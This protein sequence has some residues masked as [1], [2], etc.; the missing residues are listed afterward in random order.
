MVVMA[1]KG[2]TRSMPNGQGPE[3]KRD[4]TGSAIRSGEAWLDRD[5]H[6]VLGLGKSS[7]RARGN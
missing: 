5:G 2:P 4:H 1:R 6:L 3:G 7:R